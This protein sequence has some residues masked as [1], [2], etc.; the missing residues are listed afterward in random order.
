MERERK[1][2]KQEG[3]RVIFMKKVVYKP[4]LLY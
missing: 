2:R 3:R 1:R 4:G